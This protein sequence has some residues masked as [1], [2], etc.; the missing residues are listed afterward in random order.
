MGSG[1][2]RPG[3]PNA[4]ARTPSQ[5]E[6]E[7]YYNAMMANAVAGGRAG[8]WGRILIAHAGGGGPPSERGTPGIP[9]VASM[10]VLRKMI[11]A[12]DFR[13]EGRAGAGPRDR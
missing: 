7:S 9:R 8:R 2:P 11:M 3:G 6:M 10:D 12:E 1:A 13:P 5:N 4:V